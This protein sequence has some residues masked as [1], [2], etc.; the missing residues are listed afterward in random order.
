MKNCIAII[1]ARI[2]SKRIKFKNIKN[3]LGKPIISVTLDM[4]FKANI[5]SKVFVSTDS[6]KIKKMVEKKGAIVPYLRP[7]NLS[8][9]KASTKSVIVHMIN[10]LNKN[11]INF[12]Y[13]CCIY[14][15]SIFTIKDKLI[16]GFKLMKKNPT[17]Y[18]ISVNET[19]AP[20][21]RT[22]TLK[23]DKINKFF[24]KKFI[25]KRTN[26]LEKFY[27]DAGQFYFA[28]KNLWLSS[29]ISLE[30]NSQTIKMGKY[31]SIDI[32]DLEDWK[33]AELLYKNLL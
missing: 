10:H 2:G 28:K 19:N 21:Q 17:N 8:N 27:Y 1:P 22:F 3:F 33:F 16:K 24:K 32:N 5:F 23:N 25:K 7:K 30:K 26:K 13:V 6:I 18:I 4:I 29:K 12:E 11:N 9:D 20:I 14:P 31:S 15:T